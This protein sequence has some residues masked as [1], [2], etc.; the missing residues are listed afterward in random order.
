MKIAIVGGG[1]A[2]WLTALYA[3]R[4]FPEHD[5]TLIESDEIG[6]LGAG[7]GT[8]PLLIPLLDF[9]GVQALDLVRATGATIKNGIKFANWDA[10]GSYYHHP[11]FSPSFNSNDSNFSLYRYVEQ[12]TSFSH[13]YAHEYG[14]TLKDYAF[15][16]K[17]SDNNQVPFVIDADGFNSEANWAIH[18]NARKLAAFLRTVG[19][20]R[21]ITRLEGVVSKIHNDSDGYITGLTLNESVIDCDFVFDCTGFAREFIGKH[22]DSTWKSHAKHLPA[23]KAIP[24]FLPTDEH[25]PPYTESLAMNYGWMWKIP[26][27]DRYGCGYVFDSDFITEDEA[28][29]ELTAM[30]G[31]PVDSPKTFN[32]NAGCYTKVWVKNCLAVGLSAGFIEPLEATALSQVAMVLERFFS[33]PTNITSKNPAI[34]GKFNIDYLDDTQEV[35]DFLYTHYVTNKT[36]TKFW[37]EFTKNNEMPEFVSYILDI[38][39]DRPFVQEDFKGRSMF[40]TYSYTYILLGNGLINK[41]VLETHTKFI[42]IDKS[43]QYFSILKNQAENMSKFA[44]HKEFIE[45]ALRT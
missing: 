17:L 24:F 12:D 43:A 15:M 19:E 31:V 22:F 28:H 6:I 34:L 8:T 11:F 32:F 14:H 18:F 38:Y 5:I 30:L 21:G 4:V 20:S 23:K 29:D 36:N 26:T 25:L 27:Q 13:I 35:V 3:Q 45:R 40:S 7:E 44:T 2:G 1:T 10:S 33:D 16:Q 42:R 9:L 41:D 39:K 37:S